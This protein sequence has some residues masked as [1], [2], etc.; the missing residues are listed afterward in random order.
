MPTPAV[1]ALH[2][3]R[4]LLLLK[5]TFG[6]L[7]VVE[8]SHRV[9]RKQVLDV[10]DEHMILEVVKAAR[11]PVRPRVGFRT[12]EKQRDLRDL[13]LARPGSAR[14]EEAQEDV[15]FLA[16]QIGR[17]RH[18]DQF[19]LD[20]RGETVEQGDPPREI[21][22]CHALH[23]CHPHRLRGMVRLP[24]STSSIEFAC[25]SISRCDRAAAARRRARQF[26]AASGPAA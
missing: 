26:R 7:M 25:V 3:A 9:D 15:R 1:A 13:A 17:L 8:P 24:V 6:D 5:L 22:A 19:D 21:L 2:W 4:M 23:G 14:V 18:A 10:G 16:R 20:V 11:P 12:V